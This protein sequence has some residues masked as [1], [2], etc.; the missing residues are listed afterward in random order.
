MT[1]DGV[2]YDTDD[3]VAMKDYAADIWANFADTSWY[4]GRES[5]TSYFLQGA[6][7]LAGLAVLTTKRGVTFEGKTLY[8][9][10]D[11][12]LAGHQWFP[13]GCN[14]ANY[15]GMSPFKGTF[16]GRGHAIR[17]L[18]IENAYHGQA[19]F[20][21]CADATIRDFTL[22]GSVTTGWQAAGVV[23]EMGR[24]TL[25]GIT[26]YVNVK[27][28]FK[29]G[30]GGYSSTAGGIVAYVVDTYVERNGATPSRLENLVNYGTV[31]CGGITE[32]GGGVGGIAGSLGIAD[33]DQTI[34]VAQCEN[35]GAIVAEASNYVDMY[36]KGCGGIVGST[37]T[38][39]NYQLTDCSNT[40]AVS[41]ANLPSTGGIAGSISGLA[42]SVEYCYNAGSVLGSSPEEVASAGGIVGRHVSAHTGKTSFDVTSCYNVGDVAGNGSNVSAI[43]G[44]TSGFAEE[45]VGANNDGGTTV[46]NNSNYYLEDSAKASS[47]TGVLFQ[48]GTIEAGQAVSLAKMNSREVIDRLNSTDSENDHYVAGES[49]PRL[50]LRGSSDAGLDQTSAQGQGSDSAVLGQ[51]ADASQKETHLY[52]L[53]TQAAP[54]GA[55][56]AEAGWAPAA[57]LA[58][59]ALLAVVGIAL[60]M[61]DYRRQ[62]RPLRAVWAPARPEGAS[63]PMRRRPFRRK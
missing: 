9:A 15:W 12:D 8:L 46:R 38:Y 3:A 49:S 18:Y 11:V 53:R 58:V 28:L 20:G 54:D 52:A 26:S 44:S 14:E 24:T 4:D 47:Q 61:G 34:V 33:D 42:S 63:A 21:E 16:D 10:D 1:S 45:W 50:E 39:G 25:S 56:A 35:H 48:N 31:E 32:Q 36:V 51:T 27:T 23:A 57:W 37:A 59:I 40:G 29:S 13:I 19:L 41:S 2:S 6:E 22:Y 55:V 17:N 7:Q 62:T 43:L 5:D 60:Q 30:D